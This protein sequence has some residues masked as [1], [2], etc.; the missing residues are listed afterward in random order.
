MPRHIGTALSTAAQQ[1][2]T[3]PGTNAVL[4]ALDALLVTAAASGLI[5]NSAAVGNLAISLR[6]Q[7]QQAEVLR[8]QHLTTVTVALAADLRS[9]AAALAAMN[10]DELSRCANSCTTVSRDVQTLAFSCLDVL[11]RRLSDLWGTPDQ[12]DAANTLAWLCD[13]SGLTEA[14]MQLCTAALARGSE[15]ISSVL[16]RVVP[17]V[18]ARAPLQAAMLWEDQQAAMFWP[19]SFGIHLST[20]LGRPLLGPALGSKQ[21]LVLLQPLLLSPHC[22]RCVASLLVLHAT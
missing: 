16:Q 3:S 14:A 18:Q 1:S 10:G 11:Y 15:H 19:V 9:D 8:L 2:P 21:Q 17:A 22:L 20:A 13:P 12:H 5:K 6:Q 4:A 7:L